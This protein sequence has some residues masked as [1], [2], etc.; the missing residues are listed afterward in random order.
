[1]L[2]LDDRKLI[3]WCGERGTGVVTYS[4]LAVGMLTGRFT[5]ESAAAV[6]DWRRGE[7]DGPLGAAHLDRNL[8]F[9]ESLRPLAE[10]VG[11]TIAQLALAWNW[12]QPGVT[13]AIAGSRTPG[14]VRENAA[15]GDLVLDDQTLAEL[16]GMLT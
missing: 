3:E 4:P 5:R 6:D 15:A 16:D 2:H 13:S 10:R 11:C 12:H 9:V 1:M 7:E 14:H 8:A